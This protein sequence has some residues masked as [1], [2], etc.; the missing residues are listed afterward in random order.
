MTETKP[1]TTDT[2]GFEIVKEAILHLLNQ[3]PGLDGREVSYM[4]LSEDSGLS[5]EPESGALVYS[6]KADIVGNVSQKCQLPFFVVYRSGASSDYQKFNINEFL[7]S[8]GAWLCKE[9]VTIDG[10]EERLAEYPILTGGRKITGIT[11][12]NSYAIAP[13]QNNTQDW[14]LPV[15]V[16]YTHEFES[17]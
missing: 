14:L 2:A 11:R 15:T 1:I 16:N 13:N 6:Q 10:A 5:M 17:W 7:D 3:Y 9:P 4:G 8:L 12:F